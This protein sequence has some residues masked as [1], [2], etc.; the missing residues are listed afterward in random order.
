MVKN[1]DL[2]RA[3]LEVSSQ[4]SH[5]KNRWKLWTVVSGLAIIS[6]IIGGLGA[7]YM[8]T[9]P[10]DKTN[11]TPEQEKFFQSDRILGN[12]SNLFQLNSPVNILVMG[13]SVLPEN[14]R[15]LGYFNQLNSFD[16]LADVMLL[17]RFD[18]TTSKITMISIP[19][20]TRVEIDGRGIQKINASN[21]YG[22]AFLAATTTSQLLGGTPIHGYIRINVLGVGK[23]I[24]ALGG[25]TVDVPYD[26]KY[27]DHSQHLYIDLKAGRQHLDGDKA[28]QM[29]RFRHD[30]KGDIGRIQR[31]Q[32]L[33]QAL[34]EQV[35]NPITLA[36]SP[37]IL[38]VVQENIDSNLSVEQLLTLVNFA[39]QSDRSQMKMLTLPG[40]ASS[41]RE[42]N[43]SY[44]L[45]NQS[46]IDELTN[47]YNLKD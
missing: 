44:W 46:E 30:G 41:P 9:T 33:M 32:I 29:L 34:A 16:G 2:T 10:F 25:V 4:N 18:P 24:D 7:I 22:G 27:Q 47:E 13:M 21:V 8:S 20:D 36:K 37:K 43:T 3:N 15:E 45:P 26:M 17:I 23:L 28:L 31:Q 5:Q 40:R 42:F 11:L 1:K 6:A 38:N 19:R 39:V 12:K 14:T 35:L